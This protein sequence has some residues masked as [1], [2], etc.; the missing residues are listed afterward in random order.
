MVAPILRDDC[1]WK[2]RCYKELDD[3]KYTSSLV[4]WVDIYDKERARVKT[5]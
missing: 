2:W 3:E 5:Q 4:E 1:W